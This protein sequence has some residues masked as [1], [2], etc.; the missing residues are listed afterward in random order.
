MLH[1]AQVKM[2]AA[3]LWSTI[4]HDHNTMETTMTK[5]TLFS[6]AAAALSA[7]VLAM[8]LLA[9]SA[10]ASTTSKLMSCQFDT[11]NKVV[12]C[13]QRVLRN[14][15]RPMWMPAGNGGCSTVAKCVGGGKG[16]KVAISYVAAPGRK[17]KCGIYIPPTNDNGGRDDDKRPS[18]PS[19]GDNG[20]TKPF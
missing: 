10:S 1:S 7:A 11:K 15:K 9:G 20:N 17:P 18:P 16:G 4:N 6:T 3:M 14:E 8:P 12:D 5:N 13:C 19:R 2:G